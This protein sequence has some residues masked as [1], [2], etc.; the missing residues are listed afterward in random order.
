MEAAGRADA[1]EASHYEPEIE[2]ARMHEYSL[3]D[4]AGT[5]ETE[6]SHAAGIVDVREAA[7][8]PFAAA[9]Q[10][11]LA[12]IPADATTIGVHRVAR[13]RLIGPRLLA[14]VGLADVAAKAV[15]AQFEHHRATMA[16][17]VGITSSASATGSR[18]SSVT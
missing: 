14:P 12:A 18:L 2:A 6:P 7:F 10:K 17:L 3:E 5:A 1:D 8:D 11:P 15:R 9:T 4:V 16:A 13:I